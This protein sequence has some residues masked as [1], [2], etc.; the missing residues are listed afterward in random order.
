[1]KTRTPTCNNLN[2]KQLALALE[3]QHEETII[4]L[5][6]MVTYALLALFILNVLCVFVVIFFV[7]FGKMCLS[8]KLILALLAATVAE[9]ATIFLSVTKFLFPHK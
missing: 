2:Q 3:K 8:E 7:G 9:A 5:R 6:Y 4:A 1:M